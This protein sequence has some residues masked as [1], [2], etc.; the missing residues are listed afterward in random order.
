MPI[1]AFQ[2][3]DQATIEEF[4]DFY[5]TYYMPNNAT[6]AIAGDFDLE[7]TKQL[8]ADYFGTIPKGSA[9]QRPKID[10]KLDAPGATKDP[11]NHIAEPM[12][13]SRRDGTGS[14]E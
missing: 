5:K 13:H 9:I 7:K 10:W 2:Y 11:A 3:I 4:R 14:E 6:L 12:L 1:G 8:V